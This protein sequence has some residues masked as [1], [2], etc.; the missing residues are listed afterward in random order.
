M[1]LLARQ[2]FAGSLVPWMTVCRV[3]RHAAGCDAHI[4]LH[5]CIS[6]TQRSLPGCVCGKGQV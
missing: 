6:S 1:C 5:G 2:G 4:L 3:E